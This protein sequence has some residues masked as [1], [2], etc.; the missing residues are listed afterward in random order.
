MKEE[1]ET[2]LEASYLTWIFTKMITNAINGPPSGKAD[3]AKGTLNEPFLSRIQ[4]SQYNK[5]NI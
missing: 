1:E 5:K 3:C 4:I 2:K